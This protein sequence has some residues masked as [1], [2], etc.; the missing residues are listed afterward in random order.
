MNL[1]ELEAVLNKEIDLEEEEVEEEEDNDLYESLE[2]LCEIHDFLS[3]LVK[4]N[5]KERFLKKYGKM[6]ED[7]ANLEFD[8]SQYLEQW[9]FQEG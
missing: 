7:L 5:R 3:S 1:T 6:G 8:L 2:L 9:D 4:I